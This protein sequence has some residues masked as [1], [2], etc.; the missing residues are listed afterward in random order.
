MCE[1]SQ[2]VGCTEQKPRRVSR[3]RVGEWYFLRCALL[4]RVGM[5]SVEAVCVFS[6]LATGKPCP[7]GYIAPAAAK[8]VRNKRLGL[9]LVSLCRLGFPP[10]LMCIA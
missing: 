6:A 5:A 10:T 4:W 1:Y 3:C 8:A 9:G 2:P 7:R